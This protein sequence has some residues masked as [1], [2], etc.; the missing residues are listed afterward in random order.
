[1]VNPPKRRA[2][3]TTME[4]APP[5]VMKKGFFVA[6][7]EAESGSAVSSRS[8][9]AFTAAT[10]AGVAGSGVAALTFGGAGAGVAATV[11]GG[12]MAATSA[13]RRRANS[14]AGQSFDASLMVKVAA[15]MFPLVSSLRAFSE[16]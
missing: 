6:G 2:R 14:L 16:S 13:A 5:R 15:G 4:S 3:T 8:A 1:M 7:G 12:L 11:G 10:G 9:E